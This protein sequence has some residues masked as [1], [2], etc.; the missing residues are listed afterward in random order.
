M[1]S[2]REKLQLRTAVTPDT[3][4]ILK[5]KNKHFEERARN[6]LE[7]G[8]LNFVSWLIHFKKLRYKVKSSILLGTYI[9]KGLKINT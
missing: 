1:K 2:S 3:V 8:I 5:E 7:N 4:K 6:F 9:Y